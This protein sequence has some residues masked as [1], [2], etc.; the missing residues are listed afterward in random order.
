MAFLLALL[1]A[2][3]VVVPK[4]VILV[5][6]ATPAASD[7]STPVPEQGHIGDGQYRNAYFGLTYPI[8][9]GWSEQPAGP[10]PSDGGAYTLAQFA[11]FDATRQRVVANVLVSAQD[12]FFSALRADN[13]QELVTALRPGVATSYELEEGPRETTIAGRT[14]YRLTYRARHAPLHWRV[15]ATDARC[16]ALTFTFTGT[17]TGVLDAAEEAMSALTLPDPAKVPPCV[18]DYAGGANVV[19]RT[20]PVIPTHRYNA[21]PVR[22]VI[23]RD[24]SVKHVHLLSAFPEQSSAIIDALMEWKFKPYLRD[25]KPVP[26]ETGLMFGAP[27]PMSSRPRG[28]D[29]GAGA[30]P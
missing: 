7:P 13:A 18:R 15:L 1:F 6:G 9:A 29:L 2:T 26:V 5:K 25:G 27:L 30:A 11:V 19:A 21:I 28:R 17:D 10:P 22:V 3:T 23:G 24:G 20:E 4:N 14:F 16:H 8:P 12:L